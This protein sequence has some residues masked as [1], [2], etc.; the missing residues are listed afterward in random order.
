MQMTI[1]WE[2][3]YRERESGKWRRIWKDCRWW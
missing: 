1:W 2:N 3:A